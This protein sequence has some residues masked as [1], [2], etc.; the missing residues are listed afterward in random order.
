MFMHKAD[1]ILLPAFLG[2]IFVLIVYFLVNFYEQKSFYEKPRSIEFGK[3]VFWV[4]GADRS[5]ATILMAKKGEGVVF[6]SS[7]YGL[8]KIICSQKK[9]WKWYKTY[10]AYDVKVLALKNAHGVI[11]SMKLEA[12]D[13]GLVLIKNEN[14]DFYIK[15]KLE[16]PYKETLWL[17]VMTIA[18]GVLYFSARI[19]K[20]NRGF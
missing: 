5:P 3:V 1:R 14:A 12:Q 9:Y 11:E 7:C 13:G 17:L 4:S 18:L 2:S 10:V 6:Y 16:S 19:F 15:G 8:R 20:K